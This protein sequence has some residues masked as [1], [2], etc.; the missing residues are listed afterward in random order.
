MTANAFNMQN[1]L[2]DFCGVNKTNIKERRLADR[3][4]K[5]ADRLFGRLKKIP[6]PNAKFYPKEVSAKDNTTILGASKNYDLV[7]VIGL[8]PEKLFGKLNKYKVQVNKVP[9]FSNVFDSYESF[10]P[11]MGG[12][13]ATQISNPGQPSAAGAIA[14]GTGSFARADGRNVVSLNFNPY[15]LNTKHKKKIYEGATKEIA[16]QRSQAAKQISV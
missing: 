5:G 14:G 8:E 16:E 6:N 11:E 9:R 15:D 3:H 2:F 12:Q 10:I 13:N 1:L 7:K 4:K